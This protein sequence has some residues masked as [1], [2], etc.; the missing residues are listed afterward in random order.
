MSI[1]WSHSD[2]LLGS[3]PTFN[4]CRDLWKFWPLWNSVSVVRKF[5]KS[6]L[7]S[8]IHNVWYMNQKFFEFTL[9]STSWS[10][11]IWTKL[12]LFASME[13]LAQ[14]MRN[15]SEEVINANLAAISWQ[16]KFWESHYWWKS[17]DW[18][19]HGCRNVCMYFLSMAS[20]QSHLLWSTY[21]AAGH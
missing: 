10:S 9:E 4:V 20:L 12:N 8:D 15:F 16:H 14:I 1:I 21:E 18:K 11:G 2:Q 13:A 5:V 6:K 3:Y 19:K 17:F 7:S